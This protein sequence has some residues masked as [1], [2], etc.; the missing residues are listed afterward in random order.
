MKERNRG[1]TPLKIPEVKKLADIYGIEFSEMAEIVL[2][3]C[4]RRN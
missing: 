2:V 1:Y 4:E 3:T